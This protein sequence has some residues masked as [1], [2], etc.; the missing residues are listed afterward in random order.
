MR[1]LLLAAS[2]LASLALAAPPLGTVKLENGQLSLDRGQG[3]EPLDVGCVATSA[4]V[5]QQLHVACDDG[6][7]RTFSLEGP[8]TLVREART[9][10][11]LRAL[12]LRDDE[13]WVEVTRT[14]ARPLEEAA[15]TTLAVSPAAPVAPAAKQAPGAPSAEPGDTLLGPVRQTGFFAEAGVRLVIPIGVLAVGGTFEAG[16]TWRAAVPFA[17]RVRLAPLAGVTATNASFPLTTSGPAGLASGAVD[18]MFDGRYFAVGL[19][20]GFG[21]YSEGFTGFGQPLYQP[22]FTI[23]QTLRVG[24]LDGL[25]L[26]AQTQV[27]LTSAGFAFYGAEGT[28][29]IPIQRKWLLQ[30]RGGGSAA[31]YAFGEVGMRIGVGTEDR[32]RF[33]LVPSLGGTLIRATAGPSVGL[34]AEY[35]F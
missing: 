8:P 22:G 18:A 9:D 14:E 32:A 35:R 24:A 33:F 12:F 26:S 17:V 2:V 6:R 25:A 13:A 19:G 28:V 29:Q 30:L 4:V 7:V 20:V 21:H 34:G 16:L 31:M 3:V 23:S 5:D 15:L 27:V 1:T 11:T 10:G